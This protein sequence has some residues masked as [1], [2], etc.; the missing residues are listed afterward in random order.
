[1]P[2]D[3]MSG[4][5]TPYTQDEMLDTPLPLR[6]A[7][8]LPGI[9]AGL[10]FQAGRGARTIMAGG[11]FMDDARFGAGRKARRYGAF[12]KGSNTLNAADMASGE[13]Y[14]KFGRRS[15]RGARLAAAGEKQPLFFGARA[16][17]IT[18]RPR[19]LRRNSSISVFGG[20]ESTYTYAQSARSFGKKRFGLLGKLADE[21]GAAKDEN[22]LGPGLLAS[23]TAGR[24][25]DL[26]ER[27]AYAGSTRALTKLEGST[28]GISRIASMNNPLLLAK[29]GTTPI[30]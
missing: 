14:L 15:S 6:M 12:R 19:A 24:R 1:M 29:G 22:I 4:M 20:S 21:V 30:A 23:I 13:Q 5:P 7:E 26:L 27:R 17:T 3:P 10:G 18:A 2:I 11:G 16:N 25:M 8:S 9:S 28:K